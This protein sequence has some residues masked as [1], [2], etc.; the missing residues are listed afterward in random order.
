MVEA[1]IGIIGGTGLYQMEGLTRVHEV[2]PETP[3]GAPSDSIIV[4]DLQGVPVA[5]LPRHGRGHRLNPSQVPARANIFALKALGVERI[6]S[7]S[8]VGSLVEEARPL[9]LVA[10]TQLIDRTRQRPSTFFDD[11][12]AVHIAFADPFCPQL[13]PLLADA[14]RQVGAMLHPSGTYVVIEGPAFSTR[15]ESAVYRSWGATIIGMTALPEAKLAREAEVCYAT[16]ATVTD[17]DVWHPQHGDV[18]VELIVQNL[19]Q[20]V[21]TSKRVLQ[22]LIP[23]IPRERHCGCDTALKN[24]IA[25]A[26]QYIAP[27]AKQRLRPLLH[28]YLDNER[29]RW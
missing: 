25:T 28:K 10:P 2:W 1:R 6:I 15:A 9:D 8:A 4:G 27:E 13:N 5:F 22:H 7:V 21:A 17:Y 24:A 11:G 12:M 18:T 16:L 19:R 14:A 26:K 23:A 29:D 20:N 3:F